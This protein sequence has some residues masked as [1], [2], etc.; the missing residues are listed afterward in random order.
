MS[1]DRGCP[2]GKKRSEYADCEQ[3]YCS[4]RLKKNDCDIVFD[5][6][7]GHNGEY[8]YKCT[9]CGKY[10]WCSSYDKF[11]KNEPLGDCTGTY[12]REK[13]VTR[14]INNTAT[15]QKQYVCVRKSDVFL[16]QSEE[17]MVEYAKSDMSEDTDR[18]YELDPEVKF[19]TT[20]EVIK[21]EPVYRGGST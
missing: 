2:C 7:S 1:N 15:P 16:I 17:Q 21:P 14:G 4:R 20:V 10:D 19:K 3:L 8:Y 6:V 11:E 5:F 13:T 9:V 12:K 18:Y